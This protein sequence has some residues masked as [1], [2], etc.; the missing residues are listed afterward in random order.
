MGTLSP[1]IMWPRLE[2]IRQLV[3]TVHPVPNL[4]KLF[5]GTQ[6]LNSL[7][8]EPWDPNR[9]TFFGNPTHGA[10]LGWEILGMEAGGS[11]YKPLSMNNIIYNTI[12]LY[13]E[14]IA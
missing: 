7:K 12:M 5:F 4:R 6:P 10:N 3:L 8:V 9:N 11:M 14:L 13:Y 1:L 2:A